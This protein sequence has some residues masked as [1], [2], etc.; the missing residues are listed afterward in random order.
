MTNRF[1]DYSGYINSLRY[2][3]NN[4]N[5]IE[6][7]NFNLNNL[8]SKINE[9]NKKNSESLYGDNL[10]ISSDVKTT[11]LE[12]QLDASSN[13][14]TY[15]LDTNPGIPNGTIKNIVNNIPIIENVTIQ[16]FSENSDKKGGFFINNKNYKNYFFVYNGETLE[17]LWN[18]SYNSWNVLKYSGYFR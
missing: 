12:T 6:N 5:L 1:S 15:I 13:S 14:T 2:N 18:T 16:I 7:I 17:L 8:R 10:N 3:T 9:N 4:R 11:Y